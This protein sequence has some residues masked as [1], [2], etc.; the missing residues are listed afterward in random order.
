[1]TRELAKEIHALA[2]AKDA[3]HAGRVCLGGH[4][5][6]VEL[7]GGARALAASGI[8]QLKRV[9]AAILRRLLEER[10]IARRLLAIIETIVS[11]EAA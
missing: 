2:K 9:L 6:R 4:V 11:R 3:L 10:A 7:N 5:F 8:R 1:M